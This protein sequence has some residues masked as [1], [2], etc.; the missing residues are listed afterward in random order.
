MMNA[1]AIYQYFNIFVCIRIFFVEHITK[2]RLKELMTW[3][4]CQDI[5]V[6]EVGWN[7]GE[8]MMLE[9]QIVSTDINGY[10]RSTV[11]ING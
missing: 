6:P 7:N 9:R 11:H 1:K 5:L 8:Q 4:L 10:I 2:C 3:P